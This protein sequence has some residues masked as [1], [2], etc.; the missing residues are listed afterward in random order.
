MLVEDMDIGRFTYPNRDE[1]YA[2]FD[3]FDF[4]FHVWDKLVRGFQFN[5]TRKQMLKSGLLLVRYLNKVLDA[6]IANGVPLVRFEGHDVLADNAMGTF[7]SEIGNKLA[8]IQPPFAIVWWQNDDGSVKV[9]MRGSR[10]GIVDLSKI[11]KKY[12]GGGHKGAASFRLKSLKD[13][14]WKSI[15]RR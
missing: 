15:K 13:I 11:A 1:F 3:L 10:N 2:Y 7:R 4:D 14:P 6:H 9:S 12:G 5:N 8:R